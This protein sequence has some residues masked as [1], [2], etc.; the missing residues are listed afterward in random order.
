MSDL[1]F[2]VPDIDIANYANDNTLHITKR[3]LQTVLTDLKEESHILLKWFTD[4]FLKANP[5]KYHLLISTTEKRHLN[6]E[7]IE[8]SNSKCEK[9]LETKTDYKLM[10]DI[11][12]K[13][14][15]KKLVKN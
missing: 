12:D 15:G 9:L 5:E 7:G 11:H 14:L 10:F 8:I 3:H 6:A 13:L 1:F 2:F 4:N